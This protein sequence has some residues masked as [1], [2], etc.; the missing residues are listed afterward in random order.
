MQCPSSLIQ[1]LKSLKGSLKKSAVSVHSAQL[2][3]QVV[4]RP[5][6]Y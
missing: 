4:L 6:P 3:G 5:T 2:S 1:F